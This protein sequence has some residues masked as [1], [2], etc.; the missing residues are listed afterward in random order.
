V[1]GK[2]RAHAAQVMATALAIPG[3]PEQQII[4]ERIGEQ[5]MTNTFTQA[6][7]ISDGLGS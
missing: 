4:C 1:K 5:T 2:G 6:P 3:V 7:G